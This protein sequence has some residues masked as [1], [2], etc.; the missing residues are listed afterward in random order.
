MIATSLKWESVEILLLQPLLS[1]PDPP[2]NWLIY[3]IY[4]FKSPCVTYGIHRQSF[5]WL[6]PL[7]LVRYVHLSMWDWAVTHC[8]LTTQYACSL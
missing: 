8:S 4:L 6:M 2:H 1:H 3:I 7:I 5:M